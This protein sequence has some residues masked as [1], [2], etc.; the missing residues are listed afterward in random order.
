MK[1]IKDIIFGQW[2]KKNKY[3]ILVDE[4]NKDSKKMMD[5][6]SD[7]T[8]LSLPI[9]SKKKL[10]NIRN[11]KAPNIFKLTN[12]RYEIVNSHLS[13]PNRR[14]NKLYKEYIKMASFFGNIKMPLKNWNVF[15]KTLGNNRAG[16]AVPCKD[17]NWMMNTYGSATDADF[18]NKRGKDGFDQLPKS[19]KTNKGPNPYSGKKS[20]WRP[21]RPN[22]PRDQ[23]L[24]K[25]LNFG[26]YI[27]QPPLFTP[28][29]LKNWNPGKTG[30]AN[31]SLNLPGCNP[32]YSFGSKLMSGPNNVGF[33]NPMLMYK[34]AGGNTVNWATKKQFLP[35]Y[36]D[37]KIT[38][39]QKN[40]NPTGWLSKHGTV[41]PLKLYNSQKKNRKFETISSIN[42]RN[43]LGGYGKKKTVDEGDT[44][45][46][47][48]KGVII[49]KRKTKNLKKH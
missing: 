32:Y 34:G 15:T 24:M 41:Q 17:N 2:L 16:N 18:Y 47:C 20:S 29:Q 23:A 22:G 3:I 25:G 5:M 11:L 30:R 31:K 40:N 6:F 26:M 46:I 38:K 44:I 45:V 8:L 33:K 27:N 49:K 48:K 36:I 43:Y 28:H 37:K 39:V 10:K 12:K 21:P 35:P 4:T 1:E 19:I 14:L 42:P 7:D 9:V 13:T